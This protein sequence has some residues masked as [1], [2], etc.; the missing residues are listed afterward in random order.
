[1]YDCCMTVVIQI[2]LTVLSTIMYAPVPIS[3]AKA[4][5][6]PNVKYNLAYRTKS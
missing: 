1:M 3:H 4:K 6:K 5:N 2:I